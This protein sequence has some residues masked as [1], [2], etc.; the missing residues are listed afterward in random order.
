MSEPQGGEVNKSPG[1]QLLDEL[2]TLNIGVERLGAGV[3]DLADVIAAAA[4]IELAE[5]ESEEGEAKGGGN[6]GGPLG[7][8]GSVVADFLSNLSKGQEEPDDSG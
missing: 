7:A 8:L 6:G 2:H 1:Q 5:E 4:G 3:E